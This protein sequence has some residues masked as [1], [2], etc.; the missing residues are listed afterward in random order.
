MEQ[1]LG[2]Q[3]NQINHCGF[4]Q[5]LAEKLLFIREF[6]FKLCCDIYSLKHP[7]VWVYC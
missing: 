7:P 3:F 5:L 6:E 4:V 2:V 1:S